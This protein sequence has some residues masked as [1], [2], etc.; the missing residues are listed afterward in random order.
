[1]R[2]ITLIAVLV[3]SSSGS[4][5][6]QEYQEFIS[7]EDGFKAT[8]PGTPTMTTT[9]FKSEYG[10]DLPAHLYTVTKGQERYTALVADYRDIKKLADERAAKACPTGQGDE[11]SCG[12]NNAGRG[13][14]KEELGG[15]LLHATFGFIQRDAKMTHLAWAWQDLVEGYEIQIVNN[16]DQSQTFAY[17]SMH[18]NR[19]Y[20]LEATVP[21]GAAVPGLFQQSMGYVDAEGRGVRYALPY[22]NVHAEWPNDFPAQPMRTGQGGGGG[23]GAGAGAPAAPAGG[24]GQ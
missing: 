15:A 24:R 20:I 14:W 1:M 11:R 8:F 19:L 22:S 12:L 18:Q 6:A 10:V 9:T 23:R 4:V 5:L 16:R 3:L 17:I 2:V 7:R 13:Y 21:R